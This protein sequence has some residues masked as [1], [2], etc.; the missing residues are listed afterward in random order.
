MRASE[1]STAIV[2]VIAGASMLHAAVAGSAMPAGLG[3]IDAV[4]RAIFAGAIVWLSARSSRHPWLV[5]SAIAVVAAPSLHTQIG[6]VAAAGIAMSAQRGQRYRR[7]RGAAI[8]ALS[9]PALL[10]QEAGPLWRLSGGAIDDPFGTS[11]IVVLLAVAPVALSGWKRL[12]RTRRSS[13]RRG[14]R[15]SVV[16]V[17]GIAAFSAIVALAAIPNIARAA[18]SSRRAIDLGSSGELTRSADAFVTA[19]DEWGEANRILSGPWMLPGRLVPVLGQH[20]RASQVI[21]GQASALSRSAAIVANRIPPDRLVVDSRVDVDRLDALIPAVDAL[22]ETTSRARDRVAATDSPWLAPPI[23]EAIEDAMAVLEPADGIVGASAGG[24]RVA[25]DLL[26]STEPSTVLVMFSTPAEVRGSGGFVG[27][28]A[29]FQTVD[30]RVE[31]IA[32]RRSS[33]LNVLLEENDAALRSDTEFFSRYGRFEIE[34][35]IQDVTISPDF[36]SVAATAADLYAQATGV[37]AEAVM[38]VDPLAID[39]LLTFSGPIDLPDGRELRAGSA[40][41]SLL[42][43]QYEWFEVDSEREAMLDGVATEV[44]ARLMAEPPDPVAFLGELAPLADRGRIALWIRSDDGSIA[45]DLGIGG[46]FPRSGGDLFAL[47][48]QNAGQNKIDPYLE[49]TVEVD[50][51]LDI[52]RNEIAHDVHVTLRNTAA[53]SG[54][55]PA[56]IESNDQGLASGTNRMTLS[57]YSPVPLLEVAVDSQ[58]VPVS[59]DREFGVGVHSIPVVLGPGQEASIDFRLSGSMDLTSG[60]QLTVHAQ[61]LA[62]PDDVLWAIARTD[63]DPLPTPDGWTARSGRVQLRTRLEATTDVEVALR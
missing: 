60:Y 53:S 63:G 4:Y 35:H 1:R 21:T 54:L 41:Q 45:N 12:S 56:V 43:D 34:R 58:P 49:R 40:A 5:I 52:A 24:L 18:E 51:T 36:P 37:S 2:E 10:L 33:E 39:S 6:A 22:A 59:S 13:I 19:G 17:A 20:V 16:V 30:G 26:G 28:W 25:N 38:L 3:P 27:S 42:I 31:L 50:T 14:A 11:T 48:H 29:E 44:F 57:I 23:R 32:N 61:P 7:P 15:H 62:R 8:A 47:I 46:A 9:L 55:A